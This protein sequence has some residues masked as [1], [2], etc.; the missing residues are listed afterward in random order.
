MKH[1]LTR[2]TP[3][4]SVSRSFHP[5]QGWPTFPI[6]CQRQSATT[7]RQKPISSTSTP[8]QT[9]RDPPNP[10]PIEH[11]DQEA[12]KVVRRLKRYGHTAYL[13]GGCVRDLLLGRTPKDFDIG[14]SARPRQVKHLFR[15]SRIIG[16]RF[17]LVHVVFGKKV[18]EV[19]TFR[20][21]HEAPELPEAVEDPNGNN[22]EGLAPEVDDGPEADDRDLLIRSDNVFGTP[23]QD[24]FRR[25]FTVNGLFY[26]P[27]TS[28]VIDHV[29]G[30]ADLERRVLRTIGDPDVRFREDPV[31]IV[32]AIKF[33]ARLHFAI[34]PA[35]F[36]AMIRNRGE[37]AKAA[38]PR[39]AEEI[40]RLAQGGAGAESFRLMADLGILQYVAPSVQE[41]LAKSNE[42]VAAGKPSEDAGPHGLFW[43][44]LEAIDRWPRGPGDLSRATVLGCV[45][46]PVYRL[47]LDSNPSAQRDPGAAFFNAV[48]PAISDRLLSRREADRIKLIYVAQRRLDSPPGREDVPQQ[49]QPQGGRDGGQ[50]GG[51]RGGRRRRRGGSG[52]AAGG[53]GLAGRDYF[54]EAVAYYRLDATAR[55]RS[56]DAWETWEA[57]L[58]SAP[59]VREVLP[60]HR[61]DEQALANIPHDLPDDDKIPTAEEIAAV[62]RL[63]DDEEIPFRRRRRGGRGRD[64]GRG[65][66]R[67]DRGER[68]DGRGDRGPRDSGRPGSGP[69]AGAPGEMSA[70]GDAPASI[71]PGAVPIPGLP[72]LR[73]PVRKTERAPAE[74]AA[75]PPPK[76]TPAERIAR[77]MHSDAGVLINPYTN[78][79]YVPRKIWEDVP[80]PALAA[81]AVAA[82]T[83]AASAGGGGGMQVAVAATDEKPEITGETDVAEFDTRGEPDIDEAV[84]M[85]RPVRAERP[86]APKVAGAGGEGGAGATGEGPKKRRRRGRRGRGRGGR[87][88][89]G[90]QGGGN[91]APPAT[92]GGD[93][94]S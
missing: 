38:P 44:H 28:Q 76:L 27:E 91:G 72:R 18:I 63:P 40:V 89:G 53:K 33:A 70:R 35:T 77:A 80:T 14:T 10:I 16:R 3:S 36:D 85:T 88:G 55:G 9:H 48:R 5:Q 87:E 17:R 90:E 71:E 8:V 42:R 7:R 62:N 31:R 15:N 81:T 75:P 25:D 50:G 32:R 41:A 23:E 94:A 11:V 61:R 69:G 54:R 79:P 52:A 82:A 26:D 60:F 20:S 84:R 93:A 92:G 58:P 30:L 64:E 47:A 65:D 29:G 12:L 1:R 86:A 46:G 6:G 39:L 78:R 67:G 66:G 73:K 83:A 51:R 49:G 2:W 57:L 24:A 22:A 19:A 37:L 74:P 21:T 56:S 45:Y 34:D 59:P 13:V 68:G 4:T 43:R